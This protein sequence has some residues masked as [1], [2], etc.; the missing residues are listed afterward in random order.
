MGCQQTG[1]AFRT[2]NFACCR[3]DRYRVG[4]VGRAGMR[5]FVLDTRGPLGTLHAEAA[6][7]GNRL[8]DE[9]SAERGI[10]AGIAIQ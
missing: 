8:P 9:L 6:G 1:A 7:N 3:Y 10:G 2:R 5:L 4:R